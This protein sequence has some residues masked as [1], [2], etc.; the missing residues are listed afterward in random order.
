MLVALIILPL[1]AIALI[2]TFAAQAELT[3]RQTMQALSY[4][5]LAQIDIEDNELAGDI[6]LTPSEFAMPGSGL[7][8]IARSNESILWESPS[9]LVALAN[10]AWPVTVLGQEVFNRIE[11]NE[12]PHFNWQFSVAI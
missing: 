5:L 4:E 3:E 9:L 6:A 10:T 11:L 1:F 12:E 8:A 2:K 7:Y